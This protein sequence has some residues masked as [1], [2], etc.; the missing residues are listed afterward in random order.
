MQLC[1][2]GYVLFTC[3]IW[4]MSSWSYGCCE[5]VTHHGINIVDI[6]IVALCVCID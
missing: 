4:L 6:H 5:L 2:Y 3:A 1:K